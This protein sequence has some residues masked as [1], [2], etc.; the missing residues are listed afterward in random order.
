MLFCADVNDFLPEVDRCLIA[1][2]KLSMIHLSRLKQMN[3]LLFGVKEALL[4]II[5]KMYL[6]FVF[7]VN[8]GDRLTKCTSSLAYHPGS[9]L[10]LS[11][12]FRFV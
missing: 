5:D 4:M 6:F 12:P 10:P 8:A 3:Y 11:R 1:Y 9:L 2:I 7:Y